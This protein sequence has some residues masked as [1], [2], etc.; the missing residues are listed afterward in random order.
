VAYAFHLPLTFIQLGTVYLAV[1]L[2]RQVPVT[3]GGMGVIEVSLLT[4]LVTAGAGQ[5]A[6]AATVLGYRLLS[7]WL[8]IP[9][10]LLTWTLLRDRTRPRQ[11]TGSGDRT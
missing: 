5:A 4:A 9:A 3:P 1:Q 8:I 6:A 7:C 10:G 11:E 2:I